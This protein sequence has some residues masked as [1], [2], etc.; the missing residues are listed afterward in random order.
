MEFVIREK[1]PNEM[2]WKVQYYD[3]DLNTEKLSKYSFESAEV[4][5]EYGK[6][7]YAYENTGSTEY[8]G[9]VAKKNADW[10]SETHPMCA[11][12]CHSMHPEIC[13]SFDQCPFWHR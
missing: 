13:P 12:G 7:Y 11:D 9:V 4:A 6:A 1:K 5:E 3:T 10:W 2:V 8:V